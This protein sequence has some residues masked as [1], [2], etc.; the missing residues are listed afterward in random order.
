MKILTYGSSLYSG[1]SLPERCHLNL[2]VNA[3]AIVRMKKYFSY[4]QYYF[5]V[6]IY[7]AASLSCDQTALTRTP[8]KDN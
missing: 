2:W 8:E 3:F 5:L 7:H 1:I 4:F 6:S